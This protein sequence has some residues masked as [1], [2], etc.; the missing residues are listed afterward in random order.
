MRRSPRDLGTY[1]KIE[2][3]NIV[4]VPGAAFLLAPPAQSA[5]IAAMMLASV[6]CMGFLLVGARYWAALDKRLLHR[7]RGPLARALELADRLEKPLVTLTL[8]SAGALAY[9][10][11]TLG[12]TGPMVAAAVLAA[13]AALEW[14]NYYRWQLQHF[15]R[16]SDF[17]RL[18]STRSLRRAHMARALEDYRNSR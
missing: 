9:G 18:V 10:L 2:A 6:A 1:A 17:K 3:L 11:I 7:D 14:V 16:W 4:L 8:V 12:P 13:L 5:E 15:D